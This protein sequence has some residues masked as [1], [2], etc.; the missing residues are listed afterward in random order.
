MRL[1]VQC[2][3]VAAAV[4]LEPVRLLGTLIRAITSVWCASLT[5]TLGGGP[6]GVRAQCPPKRV[7]GGSELLVPAG[8][9][10][11]GRDPLLAAPGYDD[12]SLPRGQDS[13]AEQPAGV[14]EGGEGWAPRLGSA[15]RGRGAGGGVRGHRRGHW[16][17]GGEWWG[18]AGVAC[19]QGPLLEPKWLE[20]KWLR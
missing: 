19:P 15:G 4:L 12:A 10:I 11:S 3:S 2:V 6:E 7:Q 16:G 5:C 13:V 17:E 9:S 20:P 14:W 18:G 1:G 8:S